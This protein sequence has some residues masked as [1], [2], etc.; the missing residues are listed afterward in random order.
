MSFRFAFK[1]SFGYLQDILARCLACLGKTSCRRLFA[2]CV[3]SSHFLSSFWAI[4]LFSLDEVF[5][6]LNQKALIRPSQLHPC[7]P[8]LQSLDDLL[9]WIRRLPIL[10]PCWPLH[11]DHSKKFLHSRTIKDNLGHFLSFPRQFL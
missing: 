8:A 6:H 4:L 1:T 5:H 3:G 9:I 2:D 11:Y 10:S 7:T